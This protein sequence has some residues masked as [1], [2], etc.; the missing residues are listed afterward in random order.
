MAARH[1]WCALVLLLLFGCGSETGEPGLREPDL[2]QLLPA[3]SSLEGWNIGTGPDDYLSDNLYEYLDG[4][5]PKYLTYGFRRLVHV[6]YELGGDLLS[7]VSVDIF[8]M[9]SKLGAFGI[10]RD[11]MP[12]RTV[13][14]S[15]G[16]EGYRSGFM[17]EAWIDS[18]YVC[19]MADD[20]RLTLI[21]MQDRLMTWVCNEVAGD[22][23]LPSILTQLPSDGLVPL[24]ERY[25]GSDLLGHT[26]LPGGVI[27]AYTIGGYEAELFFSELGSE[28]AVTEAMDKLRAYQTEW[29]TIIHEVPSIG[30][31]GFRFSDPGLGAGVVAGTSRYIA[32]VHG[33]LLY[34]AQLHLLSRLVDRLGQ[35]P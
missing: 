13:L 7:S 6:R 2:T 4:A 34:D 8:D 33:E 12:A 14:Q 22:S 30:T 27:A 9:G 20:D 25:V 26:F 35:A 29:G 16:T 11:R 3:P 21:S 19:T 5:A 24:S 23:S 32:G 10:Y 15:W 1:I 28:D 17:A 18:I 31:G